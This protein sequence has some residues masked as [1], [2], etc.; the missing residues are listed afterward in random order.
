MYDDFAD[1]PSGLQA[2]ELISR[3]KGPRNTINYEAAEMFIGKKLKGNES[4]DELIE[5]LIEKKAEGGR[6]GFAKGKGVD[7]LRRGFLK[8]LGAAGAGIAALKTGLLGLG[9]KGATKQAAKE[10]I[11][12]PGA[13]GKPEW[14]DALVTRVI[15]EGDDVT[16]TMSTKDRQNVYRKKIDDETEILVTQDLDEG[17]TRIDID[18]STRNVMGYDDPPTV[19]LQVIDEIVRRWS[20][21]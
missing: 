4:V 14:F 20:K 2:A 9:G 17:V 19:S 8:T 5:M 10:I 3:I 11:T 12:T 13:A 18:D 16:K 6:I 7:L 15:R 21:N 1:M